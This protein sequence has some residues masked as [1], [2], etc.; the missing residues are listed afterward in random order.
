MI[1]PPVSHRREIDRNLAEFFHGHRSAHFNR[2]ISS[3]CRYF[4]VRRPRIEWFEY[5]DWGKTAG[6]T[7]EDGRIHLVHPENWKRGRVYFSERKWIQMLYHEMGHFLL[8][9]DPERKA[10]LFSRRMVVGLRGPRR[11]RAARVRGRSG[12]SS[13]R[14]AANR[15]RRRRPRISIARKPR[16]AARGASRKYRRVA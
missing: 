16:R 5:I 1:V 14:R 3:M 15:V 12:I 10:D 2:A 4:N 13:A 11:P 7:Y 8:W 6:R 9:S